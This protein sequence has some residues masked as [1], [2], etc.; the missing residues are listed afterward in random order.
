MGTVVKLL[1]FFKFGGAQLPDADTANPAEQGQFPIPTN[2][3]QTVQ[4]SNPEHSSALA[5]IHS[6]DLR[7]GIITSKAFKRMCE[8]QLTDTDFQ[9][10]TEPVQKKRK[11]EKGNALHIQEEETQEIQSCLRSL[12]EESSC[13]EF[14]DQTNLQQLIQQQKQQQQHIKQNL[15]R[16]IVDLKNKQKVLQ[17]QTGIL[18]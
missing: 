13:Q 1:L 15:L 4:I 16:L 11:K 8:N 12:C 5:T 18:E 7:R 9:T 17:L 3:Q 14:Q 10:D 2:Q 6:W